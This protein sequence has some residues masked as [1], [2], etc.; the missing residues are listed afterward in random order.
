MQIRFLEIAE[1]TLIVGPLQL[2]NSDRIFSSCL[3]YCV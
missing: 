2:R 3:P 1:R